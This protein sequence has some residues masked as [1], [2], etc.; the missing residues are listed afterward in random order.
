MQ[1]K[2][3]IE[4]PRANRLRHWSTQLLLPVTRYTAY[5]GTSGVFALIV[6]VPRVRALSPGAASPPDACEGGLGS[7]AVSTRAT[8][9][10]SA[11]ALFAETK[12]STSFQGDLGK[13][14]RSHC[15][16]RSLEDLQVAAVWAG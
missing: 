14:G 15:L 4:V 12:A 8:G 5:T 11:D 3:E 10:E 16:R 2:V 7:A 13:G 9:P 6:T 1:D